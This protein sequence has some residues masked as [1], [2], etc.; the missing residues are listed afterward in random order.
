MIGKK[1]AVVKVEVR[2][3]KRAE[4]IITLDD[5]ERK[6]ESTDLLICDAEGPQCIA[7][8][9]GGAESEVGEK[10]T[11]L[12]LEAAYFDPASIR[13]T[14]KRLGLSSESSYRF[15]RGVDLEAVPYAL[16]HALSMLKE[17]AHAEIVDEWVDL[18]NANK[19]DGGAVTLR[20]AR[21]AK[22]IGYELP[23]ARCVEILKGLG[24]E[25]VE[26]TQDHLKLRSPSW[27]S[28]LHREIDFIEEVA[29]IA[30]YENIPTTLPPVVADE[31]CYSNTDFLLPKLCHYLVAQGFLETKSLSFVN[32]EICKL[33]STRRPV[34]L[35]NPI[36]DEAS[37]LRPSLLSNLVEL[38]THN[39]ERQAQFLRLFEIGR[40][41]YKDDKADTG[42]SERTHMA[43]LL[44]PGE[45]HSWRGKAPS[46][47]AAD[48]F[49]LKGIVESLLALATDKRV[50]F[51]ELNDSQLLH[52][53][54]ASKI[55]VGGKEIGMLG[56]V[57]PKVFADWPR[58]QHREIQRDTFPD[59]V[60]IFEID[61]ETL[62]SFGD[63]VRR[64][65]PVSKYPIVQRD[66]ALVVDEEQPAG[67]ILQSVRGAGQGI[68]QGVQLIDLYKGEQVPQGK[69]S[70]ALRI[71]YQSPERTL[72]D[73]EV[74]K[75]FNK[76]LRRLDSEFGATLRDA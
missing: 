8:V 44:W 70:V 28:D 17:F 59:E 52:T 67:P 29:R 53:G 43:A 4:K 9:M 62:Y 76:M 3:A 6:L 15:E 10:T 73:A 74:E 7:G 14:A 45:E 54:I 58:E 69:K 22:L 56:R 71:S 51:R 57:H 26:Q 35:I 75:H 33:T 48:Y 21:F 13:Q 32:P 39:Y 38:F 55:F 31:K 50:E 40:V 42:Y 25:I 65:K 68:V 61:L 49:Q 63:K 72:R 1:F 46:T 47:P 23:A 66:L 30:G 41:F 36:N 2:T 64:I 34:A 24:V 27:R 12:L 60:C 11:E 5:V 18:Y 20:F 16:A 19:D 37:H